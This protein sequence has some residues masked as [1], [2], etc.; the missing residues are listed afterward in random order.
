MTSLKGNC[1]HI[2]E[3][4]SLTLPVVQIWRRLFW[5]VRRW[6]EIW[7]DGGE[8]ECCP[9]RVCGRG[10]TRLWS[11]PGREIRDCFITLRKNR[12]NIEKLA[13]NDRI[14][15][16]DWRRHVWRDRPWRCSI[17]STNS[18]S[19]SPFC[20]IYSWPNPEDNVMYLYHS[21]SK[22]FLQQNVEIW[23]LCSLSWPRGTHTVS[24]SSRPTVRIALPSPQSQFVCYYNW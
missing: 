2:N 14:Y 19:W 22:F 11:A 20:R 12:K 10:L 23:Y 6:V 24:A 8:K 13:D 1:S 5:P 9:G 7:S 21:V 17:C 18:S 15:L 4:I 16:P 3:W